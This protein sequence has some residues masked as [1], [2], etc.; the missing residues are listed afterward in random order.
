MTYKAELKRLGVEVVEYNMLEHPELVGKRNLQIDPYNPF[1]NL[2]RFLIDNKEVS[3]EVL[4]QKIREM[5]EEK[6]MKIEIKEV[7]SENIDDLVGPGCAPRW[8]DPRHAQTFKEGV[9]RKKKWV[10]KAL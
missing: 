4:F 6:M 10:R 7:T 3:R 5:S 8:G 1:S 2:A 9:S